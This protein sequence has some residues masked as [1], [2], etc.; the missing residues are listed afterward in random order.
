MGR[1]KGED[2]GD[3][4]LLLKHELGLLVEGVI[5]DAGAADELLPEGEVVALK[6]RLELGIGMAEV[7]LLVFGQ[8]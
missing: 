6:A 7:R 4:T 2:D 3:G 5:D 1:V 8:R